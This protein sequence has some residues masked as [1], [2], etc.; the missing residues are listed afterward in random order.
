MNTQAYF[1]MT[2][3][4]DPRDL[5]DIVSGSRLR[6]PLMKEE[7]PME[8]KQH[9]RSKR[10][11]IIALVCAATLLIGGGLAAGAAV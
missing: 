8:Q 4:A 9:T 5:A 7:S 3:A 10:S 6:H 1:E 2:D 11:M